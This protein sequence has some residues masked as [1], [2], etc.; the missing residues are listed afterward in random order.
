MTV[1]TQQ[2]NVN[3]AEVSAAL[4]AVPDSALLWTPASHNQG[5]I[6]TTNQIGKFNESREQWERNHFRPTREAFQRTRQGLGALGTRDVVV[7][8]RGAGYNMFW[9][10]TVQ[11]EEGPVTLEVGLGSLAAPNQS[12]PAVSN[13]ALEQLAWEKLERGEK[14]GMLLRG[15]LWLMERTEAAQRRRLADRLLVHALA[16]GDRLM[17]RV[18]TGS[19][20]HR[21]AIIEPS[22]E[23]LM[24]FS[25][26]DW[27][28]AER[29]P[30][31]A[32][33]NSPFTDR[34]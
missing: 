1:R 28:A 23:H 17:Y 31:S 27:T 4:E 29:S 7:E 6:I 21:V 11:T 20:R 9:E 2:P 5:G 10:R 18:V 34:M 12:D 22:R 8:P 25:G 26:A 19:E 32:F 30:K 13:V 15:Q 16:Y 24:P 33:E 14:L 3:I